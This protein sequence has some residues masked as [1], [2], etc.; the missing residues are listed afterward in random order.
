MSNKSTGTAF[1]KEMAELL[2][3]EKFWVHLFVPS[4]YG[5]P[6]DLIAVKNNNPYL[7]DCKDCKNDT[8]PLSRVEPNQESAMDYWK[9]LQNGQGWFALKLSNNTI[10]MM[11]MDTILAAKNYKHTLNKYDITSTGYPFKR[12]VGER[13]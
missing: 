10:W 3:I 4:A 1:E 2:S 7:I 11:G 13:S 5:Q 12:W 8:F 6:A 9:T